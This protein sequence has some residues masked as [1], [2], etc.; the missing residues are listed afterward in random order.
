VP[1][2]DARLAPGHPI[3]VI[4]ELLQA[5]DISLIVWAEAGYCEI[6]LGSVAHHITRVAPCPILLIPPL[7]RESAA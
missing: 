5:G 6:F 2:V 3:S 4:L 1:R 7:N